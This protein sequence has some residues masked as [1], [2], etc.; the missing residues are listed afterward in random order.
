MKFTPQQLAG[1]TKYRNNVRVGNWQEDMELDYQRLKEF[2]LKKMNG[3]LLI[4]QK[5]N[6]ARSCLQKVFFLN[7]IDNTN[8][9]KRWVYTLWK[10]YYDSKSSWNFGM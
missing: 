7:K 5:S 6:Q 4:T 3:D 10:H 2:E 1:G 9:F 8:L